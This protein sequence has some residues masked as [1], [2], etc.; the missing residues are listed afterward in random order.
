MVGSIGLIRAAAVAH[1]RS[2]RRTTRAFT[3]TSKGEAGGDKT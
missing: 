1:I 3:P 2:M